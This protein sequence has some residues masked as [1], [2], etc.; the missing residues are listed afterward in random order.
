MSKILSFA[1]KIDPSL[2]ALIIV[3]VQN[4]FCSLQGKK[5]QKGDDMS[6]I[7]DTI[8]RLQLLLN[9]AR[10]VGAHVIFAKNIHLGQVV[11]DAM[12]QRHHER[13]GD[14]PAMMTV[15]G[16]WGAEFCEGFAPHQG[17]T[18]VVKHR[19]SAFIGTNLDVILRSRNIKTLIMTGVT[20]NV[21]VESTARDGFMLDYNIV[22]VSDCTATQS[23]KLHEATLET[24]RL[25]FGQVV[26]SEDIVAAW[27][28]LP[29]MP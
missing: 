14:N 1:E 26:A 6:M 5:A 29:P 22:F 21:C 15:E 17:E 2:A 10:R 23:L 7:Q 12:T 27:R 16:T 3:D 19:Y 11:S 9:E 18:V 8:P 4:D 25:N 24:I 13:F 20:T 28:R